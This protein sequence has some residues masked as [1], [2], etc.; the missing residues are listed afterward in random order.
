MI[1][2][3]DANKPA[4]MPILSNVLVKTSIRVHRTFCTEFIAIQFNFK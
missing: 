1:T 4:A 3:V 2:H